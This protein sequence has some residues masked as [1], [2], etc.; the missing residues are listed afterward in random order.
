MMHCGFVDTCY[1]G[2]Q[3]ATDDGRRRGRAGGDDA[4]SVE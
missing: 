4:E 3:R 1:P 2:S